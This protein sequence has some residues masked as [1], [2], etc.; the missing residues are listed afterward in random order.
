[1]CVFIIVRTISTT[2]QEVILAC[3]VSFALHTSLLFVYDYL[4]KDWLYIEK[5]KSKA[6]IPNEHISLLIQVVIWT[7]KYLRFLL[8]PGLIFFD[9]TL[10]TLFYRKGHYEYDGL[11][12][13]HTKI[14]FLVSV[15]MHSIVWVEI[16]R[17]IC[18]NHQ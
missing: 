5:F 7:K 12:K 13:N 9:P 17:A 6:E 8:L 11:K 3:I 2:P 15:I 14:L 4:K 18:Q 10:S 16:A 1:M